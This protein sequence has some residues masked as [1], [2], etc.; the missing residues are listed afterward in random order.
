MNVGMHH[1]AAVRG[2]TLR[3]MLRV[4]FVGKG[5]AGKSV[6][7]GTLA[8]LLATRGEPVL[9]LDSDPLPGLAFS[10]GVQRTDAGLPDEIVV[11]RPD[12][13][14]GPRFQLRE[15]VS[16]VETIERYAA[17]GPDGIRFLQFGKVGGDAGDLFRSQFAFRGLTK[18][19]EEAPWHLVGDLPAGTRQAFFGWGGYAR[20]VLVVAEPAASSRISARRLARLRLADAPPRILLVANK[21]ER[22][23]DV[24]RLETAT[25]LDVVGIVPRD[26]ALAEAERLGRPLIEHAP[27]AP[28]VQAIRSLL[29]QIG[30]A[31]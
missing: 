28:A 12:G 18:D 20:T 25:G 27:D 1:H 15:D 29:E 19:L 21:V 24:T 9:A 30:Q 16:P 23:E 11:E 17:H 10:V 3:T 8:R 31:S 6:I 4:A 14:E 13:E 26:A 5:G 2:A 7:A 22:T